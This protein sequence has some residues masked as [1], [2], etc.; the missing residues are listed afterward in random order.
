MR[1]DARGGLVF[2]IAI[3]IWVLLEYSRPPNPMKIPLLCS[4]VLFSGWILAP[5]KPMSRQTICMLLFWGLV[6][7]GIPFATN[8]YSAFRVART[9][10]FSII[11]VAVPIT[12]Y[13]S[14]IH[15]VEILSR[16]MLAVF[17]YMGLWAITHAG[18][19]P[20][21]GGGAQDENYVAT[22]MSTMLPFAYFGM[23]QTRKLGP[24]LLF[25]TIAA[26]CVAA[27]VVSLSRGGFL[28]LVAVAIYCWWRSP[29]K[30]IGMVVLTLACLVLFASTSSD[31]WTEMGTIKNTD[32]STADKRLDAWSIAFRQYLD[33][34]V[35]GVGAGNFP[36]NLGAYQGEE[37]REKY[38]RDLTSNMVAHSL[39]FELLAELGTAGLALFVT[40]LW[41]TFR[42]LA[43]QERVGRREITALKRAKN[44]PPGE[45]RSLSKELET[46]LYLN[47]SFQAGLI[48]YLVGSAFIS[49][50]YAAMIWLLFA[51]TAALLDATNEAIERSRTLRGID[52]AAE[53]AMVPT[54]APVESPRTDRGYRGT[55]SDLLG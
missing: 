32:E 13:V 40:L 28:A 30:W 38:G 49:T 31:Y 55:L 29:R 5:R 52:E 35:F 45:R 9:L 24:R 37:L 2:F 11:T 10:F 26:I 17:V 18:M 47:R 33:N 21:G 6:C 19:G 8:Y 27:I 51:S 22:Y 34:P 48:G 14:T 12:Y 46:S 16:I 50:L 39:F 3:L 15:R 53:P 42:N 1:R 23:L 7:I 25:A 54:T 20:A 41:L 43:R 4:I 36:W 44:V